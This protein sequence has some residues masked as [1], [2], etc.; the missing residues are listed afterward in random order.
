M[1]HS[2]SG[3]ARPGRSIKSERRTA[4]SDYRPGYRDQPRASE[5]PPG[6]GVRPP[7][8]PAWRA[9]APLRRGGG[10]RFS[11][12]RWI[13]ATFPLPS[14]RASRCATAFAKRLECGELAPAFAWREQRTTWPTVPRAPPRL[15]P[16]ESAGKPDA[17]Q[18]LRANRCASEPP[19]CFGECARVSTPFIFSSVR[20]FQS[21][22]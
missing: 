8:P 10:R 3:Q 18:T 21:A 12:A 1:A 19:P 16:C 14:D 11:A 7:L 2:H 22:R 20:G 9:I 13:P 4:S 5:L 15:L 6:F 17:L